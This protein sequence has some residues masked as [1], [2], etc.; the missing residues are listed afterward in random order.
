MDIRA[1]PQHLAITGALALALCLLALLAASSEQAHAAGEEFRTGQ[2][3]VK[4]D[5]SITLI[6]DILTDPDFAGVERLDDVPEDLPDNLETEGIYLLKAP[7]SMSAVQF[8][9]EL[10]GVDGVI[11]AEPNFIA[12]APEDPSDPTFGDGRFRARGISFSKKSSE[13]N[14]TF[15]TNLDLSCVRDDYKGA[16]VAVL[17]TGAQLSHPALQGNFRRV[18]R[19]DFV[20]NDTTPSDKRYYRNEA[21]ERV[22]GQLAG[23]GTHVSGI[24]DQVAPGA[25][26]MPLRVLD[27][28]GV[29]DVY[30][31][32]RAINFA[33]MNVHEADVIN[34]SLGTS[35]HSELLEE[36]IG[37]AMEE[38]NIVVVAAA[39]NSGAEEPHYPAAGSY[40]TGGVD[41][42]SPPE[43]GLLAVTSVDGSLI[44]SNFANYGYWVGI[45]APG[46]NIRSTY[47]G[48]RY[49]NW[50]GTSMATPFVSGQA[51]LIRADSGAISSVNIEEAI[52]DSAR[53]L[54]AQNGLVMAP[55]LGAGHAN[56]CGSL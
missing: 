53:S 23:H 41:P 9:S 17:D 34:L 27:P 10:L 19:Y 45:S 4:L 29:G 22:K 24:V 8:A 6:E 46:E 16:T 25:K 21:G 54:V 42:L 40:G 48:D 12:E 28:D 2:V 35:E 47:L 14:T 49:A 36:M 26:I 55:K 5:T 30:T 20:D 7:A 3:V 43:E 11:F 13:A 51:A 37:K 33:M 39:G 18:K 38:A 15:A 56:V 44:K 50:S 31:V 1:L 52:R 32:A